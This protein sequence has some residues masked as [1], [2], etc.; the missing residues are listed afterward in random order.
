M[1]DLI[2]AYGSP[3]YVYSKA[4]IEANWHTFNA[5]FAKHP[6]LICYSVKANSNL[7]VLNLLAKIGSSFDVVSAGE[8]E[9]VLAADGKINQCVFS[10]VGKTIDEIRRAL[11]LGIRC[12]NIESKSELERI[13][14][15]ARELQTKAPIAIRVN[16]DVDAKTHP[17]ISTGLKQNKFG[18][19]ANEAIDLYQQAQRSEY[20]LV[21]GLACHIGSQITDVAPLLDALNKVIQVVTKLDKLNIKIKHLNLGGGI[22]IKYNDEKPINIKDYVQQVLE[23]V[24]DL[25][26]ILEPGRA[27]VGNAGVLLTKVEFLKHSDEKSFAIVDGA[28]NDLIR[29]AL[30]DAYHPILPVQKSDRGTQASWDVVGGVCETSDFLAKERSLSLTEGDYLAVMCAGAY[31]FSMSCNYNSRPR[32]AEVMVSGT[33]HKL[34]RQ[35]EKINELFAK[36]SF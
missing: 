11:N 3:L 26:V 21:E 33:Q 30:Y 36:E 25:E 8:L 17:Y 28:M 10:G 32:A 6:H 5:A 16:P 12:F 22:G 14:S 2:A 13:E 1:T 20:L 23:K 31:G 9:R 24:G 27:I 29:P 15:V 34:V 35:R 19:G 18:V 7:A 4:D